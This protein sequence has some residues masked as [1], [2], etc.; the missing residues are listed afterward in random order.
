MFVV[1]ERIALSNVLSRK[2]DSFAL[3]L[4]NTS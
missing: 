1:S 3:A 4:L 2:R